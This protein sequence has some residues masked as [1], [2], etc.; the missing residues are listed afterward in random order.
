MIDGA[1]SSVCS[2]Q[3]CSM[4]ES[5][6]RHQLHAWLL[7]SSMHRLTHLA[8]QMHERVCCTGQDCKTQRED[9]GGNF[10]SQQEDVCSPAQHNSLSEGVCDQIEYGEGAQRTS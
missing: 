10:G 1:S 4:P 5:K 2:L 8:S 3:R 6:R 7:S 9:E